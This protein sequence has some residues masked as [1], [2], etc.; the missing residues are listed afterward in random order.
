MGRILDPRR[1][2]GCV[3]PVEDMR[4][5]VDADEYYPEFYRVASKA[6]RVL[7]LAGWPFDSDVALLRGD[8][9]ARVSGPITLL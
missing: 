1:H 5:L 7:L 6:R 3:T 9:E 8:R 2:A 4:L